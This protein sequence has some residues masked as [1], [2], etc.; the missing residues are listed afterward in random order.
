MYSISTIFAS[1]IDCFR[2]ND[3]GVWFLTR[4]RSSDQFTL[5]TMEFSCEVTE[6]YEDVM[7]QIQ[8]VHETAE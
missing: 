8:P 7:F 6:I 5:A 4:Y 3:E 2:R 1:E